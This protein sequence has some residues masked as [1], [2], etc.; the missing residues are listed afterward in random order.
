MEGLDIEALRETLASEES[1]VRYYGDSTVKE[2]QNAALLAA[3]LKPLHAESELKHN[4]ELCAKK[5]RSV[6]ALKAVIAHFEK[7]GAA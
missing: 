6:A 1:M 5:Q 4:L 3:G 7:E 2:A